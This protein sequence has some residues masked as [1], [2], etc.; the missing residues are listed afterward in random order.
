MADVEGLKYDSV[1][2][3]LASITAHCKT[4]TERYFH[5]SPFLVKVKTLFGFL[6]ISKNHYR[7]SSFLE[8]MCHKANFWIAG[9]TCIIKM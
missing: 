1:L 4:N 3:C 7:W 8:A 5:F 9:E 6:S 2:D